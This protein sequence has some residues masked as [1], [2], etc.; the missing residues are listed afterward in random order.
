MTVPGLELSNHLSIQR[1][2]TQS[3]LSSRWLAAHRLLLAPDKGPK[4][5][6]PTPLK[7]YSLERRISILWG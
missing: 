2:Q 5:R 6:P 7:L 1:A 4:V 3:C